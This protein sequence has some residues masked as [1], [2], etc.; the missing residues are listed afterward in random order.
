MLSRFTE[1]LAQNGRKTVTSRIDCNSHIQVD[2]LL[3]RVNNF[4]QL[5]WL[6]FTIPGHLF[7]SC[8]ITKKILCLLI[9]E[10]GLALYG[11]RNNNP[12]TQC[13]MMFFLVYESRRL[14]ET[15]KNRQT[16]LLRVQSHV[17]HTLN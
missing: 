2:S 15:W 16:Q 7:A 3:P 1:Q 11:K 10:R 9:V 6:N 13:D 14:M 4:A 5:A 17:S 8:S 12:R